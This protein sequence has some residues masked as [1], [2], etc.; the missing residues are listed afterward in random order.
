MADPRIN[1]GVWPRK[2][3]LLLLFNVEPDLSL[4][5]CKY[6]CRYLVD[7][8]TRHQVVLCNNPTNLEAQHVESDEMTKS[9][10]PLGLFA[11]IDGSSSR[12]L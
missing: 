6:D 1:K 5:D 3:T 8:T 11:I 4:L 9:R 7:G 2:R 10:I 12:H